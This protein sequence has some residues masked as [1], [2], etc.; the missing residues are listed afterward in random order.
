[1]KVLA[2]MKEAMNEIIA[3]IERLGFSC[4]FPFSAIFSGILL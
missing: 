4:I 3:N 2:I 1:M